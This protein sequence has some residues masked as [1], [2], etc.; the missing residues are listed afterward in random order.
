MLLAMGLHLKSEQLCMAQTIYQEARGEPL[1]GQILVGQVIAN[2]VRDNDYP[3]SICEVTKQGYQFSYTETPKDLVAW[4][5]ALSVTH[6]VMFDKVNNKTEA[7]HYTTTKIR[8]AWSKQMKVTL[9][10]GKHR[11]YQ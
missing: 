7:Q 11:F 9:V 10:Y 6:M 8:P 3:T 4:K 2:R 5:R 1:Y